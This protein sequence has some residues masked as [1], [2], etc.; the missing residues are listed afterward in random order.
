MLL[1]KFGAK[2][3]RLRKAAKRWWQLKTTNPRLRKQS[4]IIINM[5]RI[6]FIL[7]LLFLGSCNK[8]T[9]PT[10]DNSIGQNVSL[11]VS[12]NLT[13][14]NYASTD[15]SHYVVRNTKTHLNKLLLFIG[16]SFSVP[17][18]YNTICDH[19]ASIGLDVISLSYPNGVETFSFTNSTDPNVFDNYRD[20]ICLGNQVSNVVS[21]DLLNCISTRVTKLLIYLKNVH[22]DQNWGQYLTATN[23]VI[24]NK[25]IL[26]GHSQGSG[27]ACY[28]GKKNLADR[29]VMFSGPN[30]YSTYFSSSANWLS[31]SGQT[32]LNKHYALLHT[33]DEVV[34]F[35]YQVANLKGLG[36]LAPTES[37]I[38][39]D[40]LS[41]PYSNAKALSLNISALSYHNSPIGMNTKLPNIWT[42][43]FTTQ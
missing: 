23:T 29:V 5:T 35:V 3:P 7:S 26:S 16:G 1:I 36:L 32:P 24:W 2:N 6:A 21:V 31:Q 14:P 37:P 30:D 39:A 41:T 38:L 17:K 20:E 19:G 12:P 18:D 43:M 22:P 10:V 28:L 33:Q 25:I 13:D 42:Y 27:H 8:D 11:L 34:P 40:N 15:Q 4:N 9:D